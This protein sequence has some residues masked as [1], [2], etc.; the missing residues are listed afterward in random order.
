VAELHTSVTDG[1]LACAVC[2][3]LVHRGVSM[4]R[5]QCHLPP[6]N[7]C[8]RFLLLDMSSETPKNGFM[9]L[10]HFGLKCYR[11]L[12]HNQ[13]DILSGFGQACVL[14]EIAADAY[15]MPADGCKIF[16]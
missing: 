5:C 16:C 2:L 13:T 11:R 1:C 4:V 10:D 7:V 15:S 14:L 9:A 12:D 8:Y 3:E 6:G